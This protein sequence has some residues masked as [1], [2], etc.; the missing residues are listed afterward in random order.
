MPPPGGGGGGQ[1]SSEWQGIKKG[2]ATDRKLLLIQKRA[3]R[4]FL[5]RRGVPSRTPQER[6]CPNSLY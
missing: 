6:Q 3:A 2:F 4:R 1:R 5:P